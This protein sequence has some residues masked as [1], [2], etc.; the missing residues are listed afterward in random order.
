M[1]SDLGV[2]LLHRLI[3]A[4]V[5]EVFDFF[6]EW[7]VLCYVVVHFLC[8]FSG[9]GDCCFVPRMPF[10]FKRGRLSRKEA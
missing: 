10:I 3:L 5:D 7:G 8:P 2:D 4:A 6:D 1:V 9:I